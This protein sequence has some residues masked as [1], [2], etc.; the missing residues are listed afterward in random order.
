MS[1]KNLVRRALMEKAILDELKAAHEATRAALGES[2]ES[3]DR[4]A[5]AGLGYAQVT[6]PPARW[7]VTD[8]AAFETWAAE[9]APQYVRTVVS[10]ELVRRCSAG[11]YI[12]GD[13]VVHDVPGMEETRGAPVL[14]VVPEAG[15]RERA[16]E[17]VRGGLLE[18]QP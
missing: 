7:V 3:G 1:D 11:A 18:V 4:L 2:L 9:V 5:S 17:L 10:D 14:R 13:G 6:N 15:A 8:R 16:V 12:D